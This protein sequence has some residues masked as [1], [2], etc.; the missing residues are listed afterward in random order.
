[1]ANA[2]S[3]SSQLSLTSQSPEETRAYAASLTRSWVQEQEA[4]RPLPILLSGDLG[5]GK[6]VFVKGLAE[7]LGLEADAVSSPTF[8]LANQYACPGG[9][10][11]HHVDFYRLESF[12]ELEE[13]GFFELGGERSVLVVEWGDRFLDALA[14]DRLEVSLSR[15]SEVGPEARHLEIQAMGPASDEQLQHWART[16]KSRPFGD[17]REATSD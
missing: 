4:S 14:Q 13:M 12:A 5:A 9:L 6:T 10:F 11:L 17:G 8:V 3:R 15:L 1:M 16:V 2:R 7:G